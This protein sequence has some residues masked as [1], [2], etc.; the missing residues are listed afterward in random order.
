MPFIL[1]CE[2]KN[3]N[4]MSGEIYFFHASRDGI[5]GITLYTI[6]NMTVFF[7]LYNAIHDRTFRYFDD[8]VA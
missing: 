3:I 7:P 5:N 1:S 2:V 6:V 4:L 8:D